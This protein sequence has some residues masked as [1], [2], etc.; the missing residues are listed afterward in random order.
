MKKLLKRFGELR[1]AVV[2]DLI[3]DRYVWG[4]VS[5]ISPE[6]PVPVVRARRRTNKVGGAGNASQ[7]VSALGASVT[8][9]GR[10]GEDEAGERLNQK[11]REHSLEFEPLPNEA[12]RSTTVKTRIIAENQQLLRIDEENRSEIPT[13][14]LEE[15]SDHLRSLLASHDAVLL[16]DYAKGVFSPKSLPY[17]FELFSGLDLP[18]VVD[19]HVRHFP[20]YRGARVLTP[21]ERELR[22]GMGETGSADAEV[23]ELSRR[24]MDR[25]DLPALL[26][27]RGEEGMVLLEDENDPYELPAEAREVYDVTGAGDTVAG[28]VVLGEALGAERRS[29]V[30]LANTAAGL[31][32]ARMGAVAIG[33]D[34]LM[35]KLD[36]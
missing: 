15:N 26:V 14:L 19:P 22:E 36:S 18:V 2:G 17:W 13:P 16:S 31:V 25:M 29:T 7:T 33:F 24:A 4:S 6:A 23:G 28:V 1:I 9:F 11:M 30:K 27:T 35:V 12:G 34:E 8:V 20:H 21:N 10:V 3:L 32:V 5:R